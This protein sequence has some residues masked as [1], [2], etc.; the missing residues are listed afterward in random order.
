M[1]DEK[2]FIR[3]IMNL[4]NHQISQFDNAFPDQN[5]DQIKEDDQNFITDV[6]QLFM[7]V[8]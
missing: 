2:N 5:A 7:S 3:A 1:E 8:L 4:K 6:R